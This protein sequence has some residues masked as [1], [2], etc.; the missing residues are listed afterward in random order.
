MAWTKESWQ[1][2]QLSKH[3]GLDQGFELAQHISELLA[4]VKGPVLHN[5]SYRISRTQGNSKISERSPRA[6]PVW[7]VE[8]K[9][10]SLN[11]TND[12]LQ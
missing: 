3:P 10:E 12:S 8:Q 4:H 11:H 6:G 7:R 5:K 2:D 1:A 9:P